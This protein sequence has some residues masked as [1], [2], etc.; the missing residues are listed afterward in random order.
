VASIGKIPEAP[1]FRLER[2]QL[3]QVVCQ[4]RFSPILTIQH[5]ETVIP[6]QDAIRGDYPRYMKTAALGIAVTPAGIQPQPLAH[7]L[8]RFQDTTGVYTAVLSQDFI[9]LETSSYV[10]IDDFAARIA[11]LAAAVGE[12][13]G[14][15]EMTRIGLRF[16]NELRLGS[17][18]PKHT[19]FEAITPALLGPIGT[20]DLATA[21]VNMQQVFMLGGDGAN[22]L[23]RHGFSPEGG[24]TVEQQPGQQLDPRHAE[25]FYLLDIDAFIEESKPFSVE[26][27]EAH[28]RDFNDQVRALFVWAVNPDFRKNVLGQVEITA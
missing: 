24:T 20:E 7:N 3:A 23:V 8:H 14:P 22:V 2:H 17:E 28:I 4:I 1:R 26:G 13:F 5:D 27:I 25:P 10:D 19:M 11:R 15:V 9:A 12:H 21:T 6:F 16:V 18:N